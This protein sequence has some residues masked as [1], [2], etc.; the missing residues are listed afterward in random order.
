MGTITATI[1]LGNNA[2]C[3]MQLRKNI[4]VLGW[5]FVVVSVL[6]LVEKKM[7]NKHVVSDSDLHLTKNLSIS[8]IHYFFITR[9]L[10]F[11]L[12]SN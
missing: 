12:A 6:V 7:S 4:V 8:N 10:N 3:Y 1:K 5:A 9:Q 11:F 2:S